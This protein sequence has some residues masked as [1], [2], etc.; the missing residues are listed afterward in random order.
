VNNF[1]EKALPS[2]ENFWADMNQAVGLYIS[3]QAEDLDISSQTVGLYISS[4]TEGL[5]HTSPGQRPG[6]IGPE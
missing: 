4:Q 5:V 1:Y 6:F 2:R 3:S